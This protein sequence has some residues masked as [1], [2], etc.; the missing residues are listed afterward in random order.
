MLVLIELF[1]FMVIM[2]VFL[3][4]YFFFSIF[5]YYLCLSSVANK[6]VTR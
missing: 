1:D 4:Y 5:I 6:H 2:F 3:L